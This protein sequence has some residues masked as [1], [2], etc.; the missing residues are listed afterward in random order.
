MISRQHGFMP[1]TAWV[2]YCKYLCSRAAPGTGRRENP[3]P[4]KRVAIKPGIRCFEL[5]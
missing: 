3:C 5:L 4:P 2:L 1:E